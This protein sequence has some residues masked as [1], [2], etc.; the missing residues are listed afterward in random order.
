MLKNYLIIGWRNLVRAAGFSVINILGFAAGLTIALLIGLWVYDEL[1]FN[2]SFAN[3]DRLAQLF[4][5]ISFGED[6][7]TISDL[8]Y[9]IGG[10]LKSNYPELG[11]IAMSSGV[12][13]HI[14]SHDETILTESGMFIEPSFLGMFSIKI[15][16]E[17]LMR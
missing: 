4:H 16:Q 1:S 15:T 7:L 10:A 11:E 8:P 14:L 5:R 17:H 13:E 2:K 3:H 6:D 9:P 12:D